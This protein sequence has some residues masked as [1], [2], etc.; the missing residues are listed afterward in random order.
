MVRRIAICAFPLGV[1]V[2]AVE[3]TGRTCLCRGI[4][5]VPSRTPVVV[6]GKTR[7]VVVGHA[8][9]AIAAGLAGEAA[10]PAR[11]S[12]SGIGLV[13]PGHGYAPGPV[14]HS[15]I[16]RVAGQTVPSSVAGVAVE[17][18]GVADEGYGVG[19]VASGRAFLG[20]AVGVGVEGVE[21]LVARGGVGAAGAVSLQALVGDC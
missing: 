9:L 2:V 5:V 18:A 8:L 3:R 1:A 19:V 21:T 16:P 11:P 10:S 13:V 17:G 14:E 4:G 20:A 6:A 15:I 12:H 7:V